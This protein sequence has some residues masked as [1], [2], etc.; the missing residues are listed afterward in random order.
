[1]LG[2]LSFFFFLV[3]IQPIHLNKKWT[4]N[5]HLIIF[6]HLRC[7]FLLPWLI[8]LFTLT[9]EHAHG[10]LD[11]RE[12]GR[13]GT[14]EREKHQLVASLMCPGWGIPVT[15]ACALTRDQ[16]CKL[17]V[18]R[19]MLQMSHTSQGPPRLI[20]IPAHALSWRE[21]HVS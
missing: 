12:W 21:T 7:F 6:A 1:M 14:R 11:F 20:F 5:V 10:F 13:E 17:S 16:T 8:F 9:R 18:Y 19:T 3:S 2:F 15:Q 4:V